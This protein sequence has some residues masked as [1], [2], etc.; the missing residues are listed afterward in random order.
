[1]RVACSSRVL[2]A[3]QEIPKCV[4]G[5]PGRVPSSWRW[6]SEPR[7]ELICG[8]EKKKK[9]VVLLKEILKEIVDFH[10]EN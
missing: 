2:V 4:S 9:K 7:G 8:M 6:E 3:F 10:F 5:S 1:M